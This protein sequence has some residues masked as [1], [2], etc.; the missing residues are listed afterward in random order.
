MQPRK[1]VT[2]YILISSSL[3]LQCLEN[4]TKN[5]ANRKGTERE[6]EKGLLE[7]AI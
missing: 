4:K 2:P 1:K 7:D 3:F 6:R 5:E